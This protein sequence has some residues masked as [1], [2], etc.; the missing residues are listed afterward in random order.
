MRQRHRTVF[1]RGLSGLLC[2]TAIF[3]VANEAAADSVSDF[4][5]GKTLS[6]IVGSGEGGSYDLTGRMIARHLARYIPS[7]PNVIV[8]NMPG[9]SSARAAG[10]LYS[11][12]PRDG[13]A[14][15]LVQPTVILNKL[16]E[17]NAN[18][19]PQEFDWLGRVAPIPL[20]GIVWHT[21][22]VDNI[23]QAKEKELIF[24]ASG[25]TGYAAIIPWALNRLVG[26]KFRVV[27]GY[28]SMS[29]EILAMER[30]EI[31]GIGSLGWDYFPARRPEWIADKTIRPLYYIG[32]NRYSGLPNVPTIVELAKNDLDRNVMKLF[33]ATISVG[34][35]IMAPPNVPA[36]RLAALQKALGQVVQDKDF[37]QEAQKQK[38][39]IDPLSGPEV[40]KIVSDIFVMPQAATDKMLEVIKPPEK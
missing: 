36:D 12:A 18:Y 33:A 32:L 4:Y 16:I 20:A 17:P 31:Q 35:A 13:T 37:I 27:R 3:A 24:G 1:K 2:A 34:Y 40:K 15:G 23:E 19:K 21:T 14:F 29:S 11:V 30:G 25:A 6:L 38:V 22:G 10:Y 9:A 26:T 5:R 7:Q 39:E 8:N 28:Q